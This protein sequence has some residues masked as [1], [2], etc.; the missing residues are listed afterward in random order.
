MLRKIQIYMEYK[1]PHFQMNVWPECEHRVFSLNLF[2]SI[3]HTRWL[4]VRLRQCGFKRWENR[5]IPRLTSSKSYLKFGYFVLQRTALHSKKCTTCSGLTKTALNNVVL[6][7]LFKVVNNIVQHCY[8]W[9]PANS[10]SSTCSVLLTTLNKV[11]S[12][13]LFNAVFIRPEQVVR[14]LLCLRSPFLKCARNTSC[15]NKILS[16]SEFL[17]ECGWLWRKLA[18]KRLYWLCL[19]RIFVLIPV[20]NPW[21]CS[22][23]PTKFQKF[24]FSKYCLKSLFIL[25]FSS[26]N[27]PFPY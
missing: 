1:L 16:P 13:T 6:S 15:I 24:P 5:P 26:N 25:S 9:L 14:F 7:T 2:F 17:N 18:Y 11:G 10:G 20:L 27:G 12:T 23:F 3:D 19:L 4:L 8:T 22:H 21:T